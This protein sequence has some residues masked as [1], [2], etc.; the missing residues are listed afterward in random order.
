MIRVLAMI[1]PSEMHSDSHRVY[2]IDNRTK[3]IPEG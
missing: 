3:A 2:P 1:L